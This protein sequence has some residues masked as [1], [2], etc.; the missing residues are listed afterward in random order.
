MV[1][2]QTG[3]NS[4]NFWGFDNNET[5]HVNDIPQ[6]VYLNEKDDSKATEGS[7]ERAEVSAI[8]LTC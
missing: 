8:F 5:S 7:D 3:T 4:K 2:I 6:L 1:A